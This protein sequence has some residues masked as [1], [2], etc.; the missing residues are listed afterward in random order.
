[1]AEVYVAAADIRA[2][3]GDSQKAS[4]DTII[5]AIENSIAVA[6][7]NHCLRPDGFVADET[8]TAR[9]FAADGSAWLYLPDS[10]AITQVEVKDDYEAAYTA[11]ATTDWLAF[12]GDYLDPDFNGTPYH[13]ILVDPT[14]DYGYF[15]S[16]RVGNI[17]VPT[18]RVTAKWGYA[19]DLPDPIKQA[20]IIQCA[21]MF[22]RS[23]GSWSEVIGSSEFTILRAKNELDP[24]VRVLLEPY[25]NIRAHVSGGW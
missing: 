9:Q 13:G 10:I 20:V 19:E 18:V 24:M 1:M 23:Q 15:S 16:G 21:V 14:G 7:N 11:W 22:K 12:A 8:A 5:E 3:T 4:N 17:K 2:Q 6:V 25:K